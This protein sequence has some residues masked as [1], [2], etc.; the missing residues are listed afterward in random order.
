MTAPGRSRALLTAVSALAAVVVF[1]AIQLR[2]ILFAGPGPL[3]SMRNAFW[4]DQLGYLSI[5]ADVASGNLQ[6]HEPMTETGLNHYPRTYYTLIGLVARV[7]H[8]DAVTTWNVVSIVLQVAA[9][10]TLAVTISGLSGRSWVGLF[11]PLPFLTGTLSTFTTGTWFTPLEQHAIL[12]G[13]YGVLFSNNAE[14]A[15]L[16]LIVI[17]LCAL[18]NVWASPCRTGVRVTVSLSAAIVLGLLSG[19]QTYSFLTGIYVMA[20]IIAGYQLTRARWWWSA[21]TGMAIVVVAV[22]GPQVAERFGQLP[23]LVFGLLPAIP[24]LTLA[25]VASRGMLALYAGITAIAAAPQIVWTVSG[26]VSGDPFLTYRVAS[27]H[28]LGVGVPATLLASLPLLLPLA[29]ALIVAV[30]A[31]ERL[32]IAA[33]AGTT[34]TAVLLSLNDLWGANAEPYRFW[35]D[36]F[37]IGGVVVALGASR[38][39]GVMT[40]RQ[41]A[42]PKTAPSRTAARRVLGTAAAVCGVVYALSLA[43]A[44]SFATDPIMNDTW[45][46][47]SSRENAIAGAAEEASARD[48][49]ALVVTDACIDPRTTKVTSAAPIAYFYLGMA[50][51]AEVDA[52]AQIMSE[53][54]EGTISAAPLRD[55]DTRWLITDSACGSSLVFDG[56]SP[57]LQSSSNYT[58]DGGTTGEISLWELTQD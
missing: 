17:V 30:R 41:H 28:D 48:G 6:P 13:P 26:I 12:W 39:A 40:A 33:L 24:G 21:A 34:A 31:R 58:L 49:D 36:M 50:W 38:L 14:T 10:A 5:V 32:T 3:R 4:H 29:L 56:M 43:D 27:N 55:S 19:F 22:L 1:A 54:L 20:A 2:P 57:V 11:A 45:N 46:P 7:L 52:V 44:W 9:V 18:A 47:V 15:G 53:R 35:I 8:S 23:S 37:L 16:C 25:L 42:S 51:P